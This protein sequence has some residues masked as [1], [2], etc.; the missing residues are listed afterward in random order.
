MKIFKYKLE[1]ADEQLVSL[2]K[3]AELLTVQVQNNQP[4]LWALV[5]EKATL[6]TNTVLIYGT[7][8]Q[9]DKRGKYLG[10]FQLGNGS[11]VF[12][13]FVQQDAEGLA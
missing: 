5:D 12:H 4:C 13:V 7:G 6:K 11:L 8:H 10:T 1:L 3:G 2:P 9:V